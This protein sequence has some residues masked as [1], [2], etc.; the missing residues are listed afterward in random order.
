MSVV[1]VKIGSRSFQLACEDGEETNLQGLAEKVN[2]R[3]DTLSKQMRTH[4]DSLLLL[5]TALMAEDE[6]QEYKKKSA[7]NPENGGISPEDL[8]KEIDKNNQ[9]KDQEMTEVITTVSDY[10]ETIIEKLEA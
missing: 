10:V 1:E 8:Q 5:M 4:N 6:I 3:F 9:L 7:A 2:V